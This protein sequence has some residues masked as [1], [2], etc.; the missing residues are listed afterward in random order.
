MTNLRD[1]IQDLLK[2]SNNP[3][4]KSLCEAYLKDTS[5]KEVSNAGF[6]NESLMAG[7]KN[8][9]SQDSNVAKLLSETES[10]AK[11]KLDIE[12]QI[13]KNA[14]QKLMENWDSRKGQKTSNVGTDSRLKNQNI[15]DAQEQ[16]MLLEGLKKIEDESVKTVVNKLEKDSYKVAESIANLSKTQ[17]GTHPQLKYVLARYQNAINE[18]TAEYLI[19]KDFL[20]SLGAFTWDKAV[21]ESYDAVNGIVQSRAMEIEVQTAANKIKATDGKRFYAD[22]VQKM[23]EWVYSDNKNV[24]DLAREIKGYSF[25][26]IVKELTNNL[27]LM[28]N[29][30]GTTFNIPVKSSN[31]SVHKIYSPVLETASGRVFTAGGNFYHSTTTSI[32]RLKK[33]QVNALPAKFLQL[34]EA[35]T[36]AQVVDDKVTLFMGKNKIQLLEDKRVFINGR[37][38]DP[39]TLGSQLMYFT[40]TNVFD[41]A[42]TTVNKVMNV[43]E[44]LD[45]ICEIDFGKAIV[46]N[47]F[48]G[49]GAYVF[50]KDNK[51]FINKVNPSM[52]E[53]L[54]FQAN[55]I[56]TVNFVQKFLSYNI[57][58]SLGSFLDGDYAKKALMEKNAQ[59]VLNNITLV[60]SDIEKLDKATLIDPALNDVQEIKEAKSLLENELGKLKTQFQAISDDIKRFETIVK[61]E[62]EEE[63]ELVIPAEEEGEEST[64]EEPTEDPEAKTEE[65]PTEEPTEEPAE[66]EP[67]EEPTEE[68]AAEE[69]TEEPVVAEEPV[70]GEP[71]TEEEPTEDPKSEEP[72]KT[73]EAPVEE[74]PAVSNDPVSAEPLQSTGNDLVSQGV[75]GAQGLQDLS[76]K[77]NDNIH[78]ANG[79]PGPETG[80]VSAGFNGA[81]GAQNAAPE[82]AAQHIK[83]AAEEKPVITPSGSTAQEIPSSDASNIQTAAGNEQPVQAPEGTEAAVEV[84]TVA[85]EGS[86]EGST[87]EELE[88]N[89]VE[90]STEIGIDAKVKVLSRNETGTVSAVN[91]GE[92]TVLLDSGENVTCKQSDL[93]SL[94]QEVEQNVEKNEEPVTEKKDDEEGVSLEGDDTESEEVMYVNATLS[95]DLGPFKEG[96]SVQIDASAYTAGGE[97]DPVKL[98]EPRDGVSEVP[99]KYLKLA[100]DAATPAKEMGDIQSKTESILKGLEELETFVKSDDK[101]STKAIEAAKEKLRKF[102][103]ELGKE[104]QEVPEAE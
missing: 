50:K 87:E 51:M 23:N 59:T 80:A 8:L 104:K 92:Y 24:H 70:E 62:E 97:D 90:E 55:A 42:S 30:K 10:F 19:V 35:F 66:E 81:E 13:S 3:A 67:T 78:L 48:E 56:Q 9:V 91:D 54:F 95:I 32:S 36:A 79:Q 65:E 52:N 14:A 76:I 99:K 93:Q 34:C 25:N 71:K 6:L 96:D 12:A 22:L 21:R 88:E 5:E 46:S 57:S 47:V 28:E 69:P 98:K 94:E 29:S 85:P 86:E 37:Q 38:I 82:G 31:C 17:I 60:E 39:S 49:V 101:I 7:L 72:V 102:A 1:R 33:D 20:A 68:P 43:Y 15:K 40:H 26:P 11:T 89:K 16:D 27:M 84:D 103:E 18:G 4:V 83:V 58:E 73:D 77:G 2:N 74:V 100:D 44:N 64:E 53:N 41:K 75:A 45:N 61:E 63:E